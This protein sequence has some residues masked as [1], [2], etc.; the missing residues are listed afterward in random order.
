ML[1]KDYTGGSTVIPQRLRLAASVVMSNRRSGSLTGLS[2][3]IYGR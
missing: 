2:E 3:N 1:S